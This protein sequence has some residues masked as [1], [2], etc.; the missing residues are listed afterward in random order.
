MEYS[1]GNMRMCFNSI[2][3]GRLYYHYISIMIR[4]LIYLVV[5]RKTVITKYCF[6]W[7]SGYFLKSSNGQDYNL[8]STY[9]IQKR[10][11]AVYKF[12]SHNDG[13]N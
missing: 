10:Y 5:V 7:F 3:G 2:F 4:R 6:P 1:F 8:Y 11:I 9:I 13:T 12:A